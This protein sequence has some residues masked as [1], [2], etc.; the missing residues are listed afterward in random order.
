MSIAMFVLAL[1]LTVFLFRYQLL[2]NLIAKSAARFREH[3]PGT[4]KIPRFT[5]LVPAHN[6]EMGIAA[7]VGSL[8]ALDYPRDA[9]RILVIADNCDDQTAAVARGCGADVLE[10]F[11]DKKK[12]KGFAL[13][14]AMHS[15]KREGASIPDA[16]VVIDADTRAD[17]RLLQVFAQR[18]AHGQDWIQA[19]YSVSNPDD[20]WRT[21]LMTLA[22]ALFNGV[23]LLGQDALGLGSSFRG[24]GMC[25][26]WKALE[27][28]P[29]KAYGLAEDLEFSWYLRLADERVH[30]A[31]EALVYGEIISDNAAASKSQR[32]RWERGRRDL[33]NTFGRDLSQK[34][35]PPFKRFLW[36]S[37]LT[38][39]PLSR[40]VVFNA[41]AF[42]AS[43]I[44]L[45]GSTNLLVS[46]GAGLLLIINSLAILGFLVYLS[47]AF[48][49][50]HL[51]LSYLFALRR[52]PGYMFWKALL[53]FNKSPVSWVRTSRKNEPIP[54][55]S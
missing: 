52:M 12:S 38:M 15:L 35:L 18:L 46:M 54:P 47:L 28:Q 40:Y 20:N 2:L 13:E 42:F 16:V 5:I 11:D 33:R 10:R 43:L 39:L 23:W 29:W 49:R 1:V 37:D 4:S 9:Y 55:K 6:E 36:R 27:R 44:A 17:R 24:N 51:P 8:Q 22:F 21:Q 32:L 25:F 31:P 3:I 41:L 50:F 7:T 19:Y 45:W 34:P 53:L 30:F 48:L 14:Y 26:S